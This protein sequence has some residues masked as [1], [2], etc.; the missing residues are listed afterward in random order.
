MAV[1]EVEGGGQAGLGYSYGDAGAAGLAAGALAEAVQGRVRETV[2]IYGSGRFTTYSDEQM[3]D[4]LQGWVQRDGCRA[5]KI[6]VGTHPE[7]DPH[8]ADTNGALTAKRAVAF[9]PCAAAFPRRWRSRSASTPSPST[10]CGP[11]WRR[12]R[13]M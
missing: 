4:Q 5:V 3:R 2:P 12:R 1:V 7:Q 11:R 13:S 6:K 9:A 8:R 10:T